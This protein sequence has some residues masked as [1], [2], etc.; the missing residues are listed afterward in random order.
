MKTKKTKSEKQNKIE[1]WEKELEEEILRYI[2]RTH[3][4]ARNWIKYFVKEIIKSEKERL[5]REI[6]K[7]KNNP[8]KLQEVLGSEGS[9]IEVYVKKDGKLTDD[10]IV[11]E[12][13]WCGKRVVARF[14][15]SK[16][17]TIKTK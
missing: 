10:F 11:Y 17:H 5:L 7:N 13:P 14:W 8:S 16:I 1:K 6:E 15:F 4:D 9:K 12:C 3:I 2:R